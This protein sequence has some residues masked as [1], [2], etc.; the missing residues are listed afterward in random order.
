MC[1]NLGYKGQTTRPWILVKVTQQQQHQQH[2]RLVE[3]SSSCF[4]GPVET[5]PVYSSAR[6]EPAATKALQSA[7][8]AINEVACTKPDLTNRLPPAY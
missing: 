1:R 8:Q 5:K 7:E 3:L 2:Q 6:L 4:E